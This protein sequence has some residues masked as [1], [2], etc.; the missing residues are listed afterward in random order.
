P[1]ALIAKL[2]IKKGAACRRFFILYIVFFADENY[3]K[4][5]KSIKEFGDSV[6]NNLDGD[7]AAGP[8]RNINFSMKDNYHG[9]Y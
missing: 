1:A 5:I 6:D 7:E 3:I 9:C 8:C 4:K 2:V